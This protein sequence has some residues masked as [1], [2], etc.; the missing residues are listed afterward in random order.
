MLSATYPWDISQEIR[1]CPWAGGLVM[2]RWKLC[3]P[4]QRALAIYIIL[5]HRGF[6][7]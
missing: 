4:R 6:L 1:H 3:Y 5:L 7:L 2:I